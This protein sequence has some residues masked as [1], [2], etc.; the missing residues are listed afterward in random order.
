MSENV[1]VKLTKPLAAGTKI[2]AMLYDDADR[3][4]VFKE[5][6]GIDAG[7][8]VNEKKFIIPFMVK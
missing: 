1:M 4:G 7:V 8:V 5:A 2:H 6:G 3:N